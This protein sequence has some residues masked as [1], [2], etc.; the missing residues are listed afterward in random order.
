MVVFN[1][2]SCTSYSEDTIHV[3]QTVYYFQ[4]DAFCYF[5]FVGTLCHNGTGNSDYEKID[6]ACQALIPDY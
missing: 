4:I 3:I 6:I 1:S 5:G 2:I